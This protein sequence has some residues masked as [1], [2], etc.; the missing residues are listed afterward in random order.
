MS[1]S[2][3]TMQYVCTT[4]TGIV[5][6]TGIKLA[7]IHRASDLAGTVSIYAGATLLITMSADRQITWDCPVAIP[8]PVTMTSSAG[9]MFFIGFKD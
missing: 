6:G 8:G 2:C 5:I 4:G 7:S 9:R 1:E 3:N